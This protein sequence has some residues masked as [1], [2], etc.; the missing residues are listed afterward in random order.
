MSRLLTSRTQTTATYFLLVWLN[1]PSNLCHSSKMQS[2]LQPTQVLPHFTATALPVLAT[3]GCLNLIQDTG[4][5]VPQCE[6]LWQILHSGHGQTLHP[7]PS[8][9]LCYCQ[10][11]CYSLTAMVCLLSWLHSGGTSSPLTSCQQKVCIST[12]VDLLS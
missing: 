8:T 9:M 11:A 10:T 2:G 1:V 3:G 6:W 4:T 12:Q 5:C 7:S